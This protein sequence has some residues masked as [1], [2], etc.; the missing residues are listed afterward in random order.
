M[1]Y[2]PIIAFIILVAFTISCNSIVDP[3]E[4]D[5]ECGQEITDIEGNRYTTV[6]IGSKCWMAQN[7]RTGT[8]QNGDPIVHA[9]D[10]VQWKG[11]FTGGWTYYMNNSQYNA[12]Y[13]KLYNWYTLNDS[14]GMCPVGWRVSTNED[15]IEIELLLGLPADMTNS[16]FSMR[17][18]EQNVGG[19]LK[20]L[21]TSHWLS[22]NEGAT[23][24]VGFRALPG[25]GRATEANYHNLGSYGFWWTYQPADGNGA[26]AISRLLRYDNGTSGYRLDS[27]RV[28]KSVRCVLVQI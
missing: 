11:L 7:L 1:K 13:G 23:D 18:R 21:G 26:F 6:L 19:K 16:S 15:W 14:R 12:D 4:E 5:F 10:S 27:H 3:P 25:G 22:P 24:L 28:G 20:A 9:A 8:Y 17:G 2:T